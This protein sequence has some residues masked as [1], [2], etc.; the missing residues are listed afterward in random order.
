MDGYTFRFIINFIIFFNSKGGCFTRQLF[1]QLFSKNQIFHLTD[2]WTDCR[3]LNLVF[4]DTLPKSQLGLPET[5][6]SS[7]PRPFI[8]QK[9]LTELD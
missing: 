5:E 9:L 7:I 3:F 6:S 1:Y 2:F 8:Q 4:N